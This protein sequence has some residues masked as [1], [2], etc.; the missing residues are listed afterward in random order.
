MA[1]RTKIPWTH[2]TFNPWWGCTRLSAGC[3]HCYAAAM[4]KRLYGLQ[5]GID[6]RF[7][8]EPH[9]RKPLDWN[10]KAEAAGVRAR[11]F[12]ASVGDLFEDRPELV[13]PRGWVFSLIRQTPWLDWLLLTKRPNDVPSMVP[14][15]WR[16]GFPPNVWMGTTVENII[17]HPRIAALR[18]LPAVVRFVSFEPLLER[19]D[20]PDLNGIHWAIVGGESGPGAR[21]MDLD[22]VR[23]IRDACAVL[24]LPFFFKQRIV[25]GRALELPELDGVRYAAFPEVA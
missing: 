8:A 24:R 16:S 22:W 15:S 9:W 12:C 7:F 21:P 17:S 10:R 20:W 25:N 1:E 14:E 18:R 23:V 3:D 5:W 11:T 13:E 19:I 4:G 6:Y 2:H